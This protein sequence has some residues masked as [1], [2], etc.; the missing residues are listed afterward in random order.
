MCLPDHSQEVPSDETSKMP[1]Q[2]FSSVFHISVQ[3]SSIAELG[4]LE[5]EI[6]RTEQVGTQGLRD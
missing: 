1:I 6:Q 5:Q 3:V 2:Q 4:R